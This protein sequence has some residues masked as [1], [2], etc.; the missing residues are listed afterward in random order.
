[1]SPQN[2]RRD[3]LQSLTVALLVFVFYNLTFVTLFRSG[4]RVGAAHTALPHA[5]R[6]SL[7]THVVCPLAGVGASDAGAGPPDFQLLLQL[8]EPL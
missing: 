7:C 3:L 8:Q 4:R 5:V 6:G 1:M 2:K